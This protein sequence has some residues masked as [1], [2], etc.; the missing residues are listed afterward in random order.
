LKGGQG[1]VKGHDKQKG[2][3]MKGGVPKSAKGKKRAPKKKKK[4]QAF[5][6]RKK[7]TNRR[8]TGALGTGTRKKSKGAVC[9]SNPG[10]KK[11]GRG[12]GGQDGKEGSL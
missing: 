2:E 12:K 1:G 6:L 5:V 4:H 10:G 11:T 3:G 7:R 8:S 9:E